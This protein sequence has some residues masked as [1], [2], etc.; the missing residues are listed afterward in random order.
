MLSKDEDQRERREVLENERRLRS[1]RDREAS[2]YLA[3]T[4]LD[5]EGGRFSVINS[6]TIVGREPFPK[7]P[8]QPSTSPWHHDPVPDE[9]PLGFSVN[10]MVPL[11]RDPSVVEVVTGPAP[12]DAPFSLDEQRAGAG[13]LSNKGE[14]DD[15]A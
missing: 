1:Q 6:A 7:Y 12:A 5:D 13:S 4:H 2:T 14:P 3:H 10:D 11:E 9:L 15:A 8:E